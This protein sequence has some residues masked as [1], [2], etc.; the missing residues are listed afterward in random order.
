MI[1]NDLCGPAL[2]YLCFS[3]TQVLIDSFKGFYN[4][5]FFKFWIMI[6]FTI[7]LNTLCERGLG[8]ASWIIVFVPFFSMSVITTLL[9]FYFGLD[10]NSGNIK[11]RKIG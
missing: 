7:L 10:P 1:T 11:I 9:L 6:I 4:T 3:F 8:I 2:I 5:A